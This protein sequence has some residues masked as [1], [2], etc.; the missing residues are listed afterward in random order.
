M[1]RDSQMFWNEIK[2]VY[3]GLYVDVK[4]TIYDRFVK[5]LFSKDSG[6]QQN[7]YGLF[8]SRLAID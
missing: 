5:R 2:K 4:L 3:G 8:M 6:S 1:F 7:R